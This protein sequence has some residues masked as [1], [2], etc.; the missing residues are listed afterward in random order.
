MGTLR[1][2]EHSTS[3]ILGVCVH[4]FPIYLK[5][6]GE[7]GSA[8]DAKY[9]SHW[10]GSNEIKRKRT[11]EPTK[12]VKGIE[13]KKMRNSRTFFGYVILVFFLLWCCCCCS[14]WRILTEFSFLSG[15]AW[16]I[17]FFHAC[18]E[19]LLN[20]WCLCL[21]KRIVFNKNNNKK[22]IKK[23]STASWSEQKKRAKEKKQFEMALGIFMQLTL[24]RCSKNHPFAADF[25]FSFHFTFMIVTACFCRSSRRWCFFFRSLR[26]VYVSVSL[27]RFMCTC[28]HIFHV[29][30]INENVRVAHTH[31]HIAHT[32]ST[33]GRNAN[34]H[35]T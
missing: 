35:P 17:S 6:D 9:M 21:C 10:L 33:F 25:S 5:I 31:T 11:D 20:F 3:A 34:K 2:M 28:E 24:F 14:V 19:A 18:L 12:N 16:S 8:N 27:D 4:V 26:N 15:F 22:K 1:R 32:N 23:E 29:R 7:C 30:Y 13:L